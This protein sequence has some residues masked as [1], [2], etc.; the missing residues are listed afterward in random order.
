[1][2]AEWEKKI[3]GEVLKLEYGK[4]LDALNRKT[5]GMYPVYGANGEKDRSDSYYY[6]KP[7]IVVGR[8]GS[9]GEINLTEERFWPLDVTYFVKFDE[10]R[11]NLQFI[12]YLLKKLEL[13]KLAKGVKPG[14]N[15]NE[16][17]ALKVHVPSLPEQQRIATILDD[18]FEK[19][20]TARFNAEQNRQNAR[21]L[22]NSYRQK[23]LTQQK[24]GWQEKL[25]SD[26][27][28]I[29]H[30]FAF[31]SD[32]FTSKG[33][34]VLLTPGNFYESGGYRDRGE[35]QKYYRG[36]IPDGFVLEPGALLVAMTEQAA[37]LL[38][39][40]IIVPS[41]G[42]YLHNQRLG[43]VI[44]KTQVPWLNEYFFHVFNTESVRRA[45]HE[46][47][48]GV[49]VRHTSP[50]KIGEVIVSFPTTIEEQKK[51][52]DQL[53][54]F[55]SETQRL[56]SLYQ[57]KIDALDELSNSLLYQAFSGKL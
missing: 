46:S 40:P 17:Y 57:R 35:K 4:P 37:G 55:Q 26:L 16:V 47:A 29:R 5:D 39:S 27:C 56:E 33:D 34:Y 32:F 18:A 15:R 19:I 50:S 1:M 45:I 30:G 6:D 43:L 23:I 20:A 11:Y 44:N 3:L 8:K 36:Q 51:I 25:L 10:Q 21:I 49:K 2:K 41:E 24:E 48:T 28:D 52:S 42:K 13:P 22:F 12:Y 38:G 9:A 7:S 14:I 31:K 53:N 54:D